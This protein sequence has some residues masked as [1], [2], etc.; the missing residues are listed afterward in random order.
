MNY[1]IVRLGG[2]QF[3]IYEGDSIKLE[4]QSL[5]LKLDVLASNIDN[6]LII[7]TPVLSDVSIS[8]QVVGE[9]SI[10]TKVF[11]Y[12]AKSRHRR[13]KGHKQHYSII[14]FLKISKTEGVK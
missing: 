8:S 4:S 13:A 10:K 3:K 6:N 7:G 14:K 9:A 11:R 2:K 1:A 12:R 5:P